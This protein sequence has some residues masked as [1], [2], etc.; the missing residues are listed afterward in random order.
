MP[1][2]VDAAN[3][4]L[5]DAG[6]EDTNGDGIREC[7]PDQDCDDLTFRFSVS[8]RYRLGTPRGRAD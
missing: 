2:D 1:F 4:Q 7:L 5:D 3:A 8:R 6:Y